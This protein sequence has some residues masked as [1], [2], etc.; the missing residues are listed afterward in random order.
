MAA[1]GLG[2]LGVDLGLEIERDGGDARGPLGITNLKLL[3]LSAGCPCFELAIIWRVH[4]HSV[5]K[6][7]TPEGGLAR[8]PIADGGLRMVDGG[9]RFFYL[10]SAIQLIRPAN[11]FI[12]YSMA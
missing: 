3:P 12:C 2:L 11:T 1:S 9:W 6:R 4:L 5:N 7:S 10:R 8:E